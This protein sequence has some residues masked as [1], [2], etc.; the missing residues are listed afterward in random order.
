VKIAGRDLQIIAH[1]DD[2]IIEAMIDPRPD[3]FVFA[4]QWHPE[5]MYESDELSQAIFRNL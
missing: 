3:R 4:V 2:G 5:K 1:A